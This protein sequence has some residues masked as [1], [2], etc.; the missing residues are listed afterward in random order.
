[1]RGFA[2]P[3]TPARQ[4]SREL[5]ASSGGGHVERGP[6][7]TVTKKRKIRFTT[8]RVKDPTLPKGTTEVRT[9]GVPGVRTITYEVTFTNGEQT[10]KKRIDKAVTRAPVTKVIVVGTKRAPRCD[11]N[12]SGCV[13]IASDVD[14][15]GGS[16]DGPAYVEGTVRVTGADIYDLDRDGDG[17]GCDPS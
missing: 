15:A 12:Y 9:R 10:A 5:A 4:A 14:C 16:G 13:P 7:R 1:M 2:G 8:R 6:R 17:I 3:G 11:P